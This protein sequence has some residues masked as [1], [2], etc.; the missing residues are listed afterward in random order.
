MAQVPH[1]P[2][3]DTPSDITAGAAALV[4]GCYVAQVVASLA[5]IGD[6]SVL[7]AT[8]TSAPADDADYFRAGLGKFFTFEVDPTT[9]LPTWCKTSLPGLQ[10][11]IALAKS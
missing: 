5:E 7:Y 9:P 6:Q 10:I 8:A 11:P 1:F 3:T 2:V 4:A